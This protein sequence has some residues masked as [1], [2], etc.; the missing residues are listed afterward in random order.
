MPCFSSGGL[1]AMMAAPDLTSG[2]GLLETSTLLAY[3]QMVI[4]H[5]ALRFDRAAAAAPDFSPETLAVDVIREVGPGGHYLAQK[6]TARHMKEFLVSRFGPDR[7]RARQE[8]LRLL[9]S[10]VVPPLPVPVD[11]ALDRIAAS[12]GVAAQ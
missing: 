11:A 6:H 9:E 7:G 2:G 10:H 8:A 3:E 5:E 4:D 1:L 12:A